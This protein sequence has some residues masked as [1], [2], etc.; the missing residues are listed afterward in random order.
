[1]KGHQ[2]GRLRLLR[3]VC[4]LFR[5]WGARMY[6]VLMTLYILAPY[7]KHVYPNHTSVPKWTG[8]QNARLCVHTAPQLRCPILVI[9][10]FFH[11]FS[12]SLFFLFLSSLFSL[13]FFFCLFPF[14][15]PLK[16]PPGANL[17]LC[18]LGKPLEKPT[19]EVIA[20]ETSNNYLFI[21]ADSAPKF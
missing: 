14:L 3:L 9:T 20:F 10:C 7:E 16:V 18:P 12:F 8:R 2:N 21:F 13:L 19:L 11:I 4:V 6:R 15:P 5:S 1:M 17:P